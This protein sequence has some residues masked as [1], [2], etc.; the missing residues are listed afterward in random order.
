MKIIKFISI[1]V[2]L[3]SFTF[4]INSPAESYLYGYANDGHIRAFDV[5]TGSLVDSFSTASGTHYLSA[6]SGLT[7]GSDGY[8]YGYANDG[9]IRA[10]DCMSSNGFGQT[11][12][13]Q[14]LSSV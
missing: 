13:L 3:L 7:F 12:K 14:I 8:L 11:P 6:D 10:F 4:L 2:C 5:T 9:H 1:I